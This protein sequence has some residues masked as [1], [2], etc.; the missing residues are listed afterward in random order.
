MPFREILGQ[1]IAV[2]ILQRAVGS[3]RLHHAYRFEGPDGVG[4][5][6]A[7]LALAQ[8]LVC[9]QPRQ[10][11][12]CCHCG[13]C[14]RATTLATEPPLV[15]L[16]PDVVLLGR[17]LYPPSI[18]GTSSPETSAIG[19][20]QVRKMVLARV[21]YSSHE[22]RGLVFLIRDAEELSQ[23]AA[24]A[25]LKTLE[26]PPA[27]VHFVL[28][29]SRPNR[30]LDTIRSRTL[31]IRFGAL[32][33]AVLARILDKRA[34]S[35]HAAIPIAQGSAKLLLELAESEQLESRDQFV[36][37]IRRA[38][39]A[40]DLAS[41][42]DVM[43]KKQDERQEL[44]TQLAWLLARFAAEAKELAGIDAVRSQRLSHFHQIVMQTSRD[45]DRNGQ[46]AL[47]LESMLT[48]LRRA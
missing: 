48:R 11:I 18:L 20:E 24:N 21:G 35:A 45:L 2:E 9:E 43:G 34:I 4:K 41:A 38:V 13:A 31:P 5:E 39:A 44:K 36:D 14:R 7:A 15:P 25:L 37:A 6:M 22:G 3:T 16:H 27:G 30:L 42:L 23:G 47:M 28:L 29:T 32:S 17:G 46:P 26:E 33:D 19:I 8:C 10:G 1:S 40:P 12:A